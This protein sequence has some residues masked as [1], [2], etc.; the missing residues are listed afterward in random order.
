[1]NSAIGDRRCVVTITCDAPHS[2]LGN[3]LLSTNS[4][5]TRA[6]VLITLS[7]APADTGIQY[8]QLREWQ[9]S[10]MQAISSAWQRF[11][12]PEPSYFSCSAASSCRE[13]SEN[14]AITAP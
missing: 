11:S 7:S 14:T 4:T 3:Y 1:M 5:L 9:S 13:A 10:R 8:R 12:P 6:V 2:P